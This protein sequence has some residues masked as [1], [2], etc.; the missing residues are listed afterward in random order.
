MAPAYLKRFV[1]M[2]FLLSFSTKLT[3]LGTAYQRCLRINTWAGLYPLTDKSPSAGNLTIFSS[4]HRKK[5][6]L[7]ERSVVEN[8]ATLW[9]LQL[10]Y[11]S[12]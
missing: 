9:G 2:P 3:R 5:A 4:C 11:K 10:K 12:C 8:V 6:L 1:E 7:F